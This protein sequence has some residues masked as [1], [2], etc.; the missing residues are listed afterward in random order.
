MKAVSIASKMA[1]P[2]GFLFFFSLDDFQLKVGP[3]R[4]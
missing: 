4:L 3:S 1:L 2:I